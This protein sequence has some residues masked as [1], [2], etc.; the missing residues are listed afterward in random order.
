MQNSLEAGWAWFD[1]D[2]PP[3]A[4]PELRSSFV[5]TFNTHAGQQVLAYLRTA[6]IER[7]TPPETSECVLRH[8]EGQRA[9]VQLIE[10]MANA[11]TQELAHVE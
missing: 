11:E 5:R 10:R 3:A 7:R 4:V 6:T 2:P 1:G 9:L 8:L